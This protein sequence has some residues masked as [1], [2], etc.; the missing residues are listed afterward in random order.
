VIATLANASMSI[1][2]RPGRPAVVDGKRMTVRG[3]RAG[4]NMRSRRPA[5][6]VGCAA[7]M[8]TAEARTAAAEM[9]CP[10]TSDM[11]RTASKVGCSAAV[12]RS[13]AHMHS[14]ASAAHGVGHSATTAGMRGSASAGMTASTATSCGSGLRVD[15]PRQ[16]G[17]QGNNADD[18]DFRHGILQ[19]PRASSRSKFSLVSR[20]RSSH[21]S[22]R[23]LE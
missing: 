16:H 23:P 6:E 22:Q 13:A 1:Q 21:P 9:R 7:D 11:R 20:F 3:V 15:C 17:G 18:P 19:R 10:A 4:R 2:G 5:G 12:G 14:A 8:S